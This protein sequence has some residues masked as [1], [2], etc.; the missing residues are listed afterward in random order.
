MQ[1]EHCRVLQLPSCPRQCRCLV[2]FHLSACPRQRLSLRPSTVCVPKTV[3]FLAAL[4]GD[5]SDRINTEF[6]REELRD[7]DG[8]PPQS[9]RLHAGGVDRVASSLWWCLQSKR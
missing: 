4:P 9:K 3:P 7:G 2:R 1:V 6:G 5:L 8:D